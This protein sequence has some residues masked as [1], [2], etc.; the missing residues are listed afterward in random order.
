MGERQL[1]LQ[2]TA[3]AEAAFGSGIF[4]LRKEPEVDGDLRAME[5]LFG[6]GEHVILACGQALGAASPFPNVLP[7]GCGLGPDI[8]SEGV[9]MEFVFEGQMHPTR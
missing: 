1:I 6:E 9:S 8:G 7:Q 3:V 5:E 4:V 2:L